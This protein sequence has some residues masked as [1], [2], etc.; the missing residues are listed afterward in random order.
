VAPAGFFE[1]HPV[2]KVELPLGPAD[3]RADIPPAALTGYPDDRELSEPQQRQAIAAYHA[4]VTL[5]DRQVGLLLDTLREL[6][7]EASTIVVL[8]SDHGFHLGE[9]GGLWRK[10]TQFEESTRVPLIVRAPGVVPGTSSSGLVELVD[11]YPTLADLCDLPVPAGLEGTSFRALLEDPSRA[12]KRAVFSE[13][14]RSTAHGRSVRTA[15][16]RY[17][18]WESLERAGEVDLELYDLETDPREYRN[19]ALA[20]EHRALRDDLARGLRAGWQ[21]ALPDA[22]AQTSAR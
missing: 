19:L 6:D 8:V 13:T 3:D 18:E 4:T 16:Y 7:L 12:W 2:G 20:P 14:R 21:A 22:D 5:V 15:R 17:T 9:H 11:L 10:S 1:Q